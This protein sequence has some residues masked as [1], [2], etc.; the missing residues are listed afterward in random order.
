MKIYAAG[1]IEDSKDNGVGCRVE[2]KEVMTGTNTT[3][4][5]PCDFEYNGP[6]HPTMKVYRDTHSLEETMDFC[7]T[8][9]KGDVRAVSGS[10]AV[11]ILL[12]EECGPG[13]ASEAMLAKYLSIPVYAIKL[14]GVDMKKVHPWIL[15]CIDIIFDSMEDFKETFVTHQL[16][17]NG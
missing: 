4:I 10:D 3:I 5:D 17:G 11:V 2:F 15:G 8:I 6:N 13:T 14:E 7:D 16:S 12:N 9:V 1:A